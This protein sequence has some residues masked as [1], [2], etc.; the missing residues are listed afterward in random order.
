MR[1]DALWRSFPSRFLAAED[2]NAER[3]AR[4][5]F[6]FC[7]WALCSG[8]QPGVPASY[9]RPPASP[10]SFRIYDVQKELFKETESMKIPR[11]PFSPRYIGISIWLKWRRQLQCHDSTRVYKVPVIGSQGHM[12]RFKI[13][14]PYR[15]AGGESE[16]VKPT[17]A[18]RKEG[19]PRVIPHPSAKP[20]THG[21]R[22]RK[23]NYNLIESSVNGITEKVARRL[24]I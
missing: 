6:G 10:H 15:F 7:H 21:K 4:E 14:P 13:Y 12:A 22:E 23:R 20:P 11:S 24:L 18:Q 9:L 2:R 19:A 8:V 17:I 1:A 16:G 3:N 5:P